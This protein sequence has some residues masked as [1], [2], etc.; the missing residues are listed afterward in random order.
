MD[1][2]RNADDVRRRREEIDKLDAELVRL[3]NRRASIALDLARLKQ[4][5][6]WNICDPEREKQVLSQ[7]ADTNGGP[8]D[9]RSLRRIFRRIICESRRMEQRRHA[10]G[11]PQ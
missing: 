1:I 8:F 11:G 3:L 5:M 10:S 2:D 7:V 6:G 4:A 9:H